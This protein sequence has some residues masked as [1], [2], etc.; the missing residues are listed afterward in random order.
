MPHWVQFAIEAIFLIVVIILSLKTYRLDQEV[1]R[2]SKYITDLWDSMA[3]L[4]KRVVEDSNNTHNLHTKLERTA[5][6]LREHRFKTNL[7]PG[8]LEQLDKGID[9]ALSQS[10]PQLYCFKPIGES[11]EED[12]D[13]FHDADGDKLYLTKSGKFGVNYASGTCEK[14]LAKYTAPGPAP[15]E[16]RY[17]WVDGSPD[18]YTT[19]MA[20]MKEDRDVSVRQAADDSWYYSH[21][22]IGTGFRYPAK[23]DAQYEMEYYY[24]NYIKK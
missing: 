9:T 8:V 20:F 14:Y 10:T 22:G 4:R 24:D 12:S 6:E 23:F 1:K 3:R 17:E 19:P 13:A 2:Y 16:L 5:A 7:T 18:V 11:S 15:R 21:A